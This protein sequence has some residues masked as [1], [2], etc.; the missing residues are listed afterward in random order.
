M[1]GLDRPTR[2][3]ATS[4]VLAMRLRAALLGAAIGVA[5]CLAVAPTATAAPAGHYCPSF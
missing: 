5:T 1:L 3:P 2:L 4:A